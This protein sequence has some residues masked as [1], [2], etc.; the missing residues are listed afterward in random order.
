MWGLELVRSR[1]LET[2]VEVG[3]MV[4]PDTCRKTLGGGWVGGEG[5]EKGELQTYIHAIAGCIYI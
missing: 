5:G 3:G 1:N 2:Y 4:S